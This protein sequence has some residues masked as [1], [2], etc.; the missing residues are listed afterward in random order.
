MRFTFMILAAALFMA[1]CGS[2]ADGPKEVATKFLTHIN[3]MEFEEAKQYGTK[4]TNDLL[5]M[6]KSFAAMGGEEQKPEATAFTITDVKEEGE[7][8]TVTYKSE[9]SEEAETL[10]LV[11]QEG[12]WFV[13]ISKE[14]MNKDEDMGGA[15]DGTM[16]E[17]LDDMGAALDSLGNAI[18]EGAEQLQETL[19]NAAN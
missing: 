18:E 7:T 11:K 1:A 9:G 8:A 4:E 6:L 5:D 16:E 17:G 13:N 14:D 15:M 19:E 3:A 10:N 12:K 2:K